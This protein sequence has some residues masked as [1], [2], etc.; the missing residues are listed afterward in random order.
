MAEIE[1]CHFRPKLDLKSFREHL[2]VPVKMLNFP[3]DNAWP[4]LLQFGLRLEGPDV[5]EVGMTWLGSLAGMQ[6]LRAF[7]S[8]ELRDI[9]RQGTFVEIPWENCQYEDQVLGVPWH[10]DTRLFYYRRDIFEKAGI[11]AS[12][13]FA[14]PAKFK[15]TL[16]HLKASGYE[17]PWV[18]STKGNVLQYIAPWVWGY[19]GSFRSNDGHQIALTEPETMQGLRDYLEVI[20]LLKPDVPSKRDEELNT[21]FVNGNVPITYNGDWL[22]RDVLLYRPEF[23]EVLGAAKVPGA[24]YVGTMY[25]SIWR[26]SIYEEECLA[27]IR[28]LTDKATVQEAFERY[29]LIPPLTEI[30]FSEFFT[31]DQVFKTIAESIRHGRTFKNNYRWAGVESRLNSVFNQLMS[32]LLTK[33]GLDLAGELHTRMHGIKLKLER[34]ILA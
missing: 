33:P 17:Y 19:G 10:L 32:D 18:V 14:S 26:Y 12:S 27:L 8:Q 34:T 30:L 6:V 1:F 22:Y 7:K 9:R 28:Y 16:L 2:P 25:L 24:P 3:M 11:D 4:E 13:A 29:R 31:R 20:R 23:A 5:S 15:E 21:D